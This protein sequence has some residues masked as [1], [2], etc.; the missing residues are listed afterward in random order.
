MGLLKG[1]IEM[2]KLK[3]RLMKIK[4]DFIFKNSPDLCTHLNEDEN[5]F[6]FFGINQE[7]VVVNKTLKIKLIDIA[8]YKVL[9]K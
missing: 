5:S 3:N 8:L 6:S 1:D 2:S 4:R 9:H 7:P